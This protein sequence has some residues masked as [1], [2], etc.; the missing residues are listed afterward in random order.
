MKV[1]IRIPHKDATLE[2]T[3]SGVDRVGCGDAQFSE[4]RQVYLLYCEDPTGLGKPT[5]AAVL[6]VVC[7]EADS[8][9]GGRRGRWF[10]LS[11]G[12]WLTIVDSDHGRCGRL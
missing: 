7:C 5:I 6:D 9:G 10:G 2:C 4:D 8:S 11:C 3:D 1:G 12:A